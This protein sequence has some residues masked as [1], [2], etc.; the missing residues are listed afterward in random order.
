MNHLREK[1]GNARINLSSSFPD[2]DVRACRCGLMRGNA[3]IL[4]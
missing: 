4:A 3:R 1:A 2:R